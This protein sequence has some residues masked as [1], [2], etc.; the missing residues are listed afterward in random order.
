MKKE[1]PGEGAGPV[2]AADPRAAG[3]SALFSGRFHNICWLSHRRTAADHG[4][5]RRALL[6]E[7]EQ[8][9]GGLW[10]MGEGYEGGTLGRVSL[11]REASYKLWVVPDVDVTKMGC[12]GGALKTA[13]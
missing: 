8:G 13:E 5:E 12:E 10:G 1:Y 3:Q 6:L 7:E 9:G 2:A 4:E 11:W